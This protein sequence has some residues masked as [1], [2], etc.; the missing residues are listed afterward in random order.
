MGVI[1]FIILHAIA[2]AI[3]C[4]FD[5]IRDGILVGVGHDVAGVFYTHAIEWHNGAAGVLVITSIVGV[6]LGQ[7]ASCGKIGVALLHINQGDA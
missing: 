3:P 7:A 2:I 4:P 6:L 1:V 5:L